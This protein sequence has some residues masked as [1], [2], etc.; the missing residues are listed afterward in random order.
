M[1]KVSRAL[2]ERIAQYEKELFRMKALAADPPTVP[3]GMT[4]A[5]IV[6]DRSSNVQSWTEDGFGDCLGM[7]VCVPNW[8]GGKVTLYLEGGLSLI[9]VDR[10]KKRWVP[11]WEREILAQTPEEAAELYSRFHTV[12]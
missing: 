2:E 8:L 5:Q 1:A 6:K 10:P 12:V 4:V 7:Y 9:S 11:D 3:E